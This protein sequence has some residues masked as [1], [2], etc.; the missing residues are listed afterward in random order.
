VARGN[1]TLTVT[2]NGTLQ[3]TRSTN[4]GSE[5]SGTVL[6]V[7]VDVNDLIRKGQAR[8]ELD[9]AK[10]RDQILRSR[11]VLAAATAKVTQTL[12]TVKEA[13]GRPGAPGRSGTHLGR[14]V[15]RRDRTRYRP[16]CT[17]TG[18]RRRGQRSRRRQRRAGGA[19]PGRDQPVEGV[20]PRPIGRRRA[21][22]YGGHRQR[23][24]GVAAGGDACLRSP[25]I[26]SGCACGCTSTRP[27]S[28]RWPRARTPASRSAP[29]PSRQYPAR[30]TRVG[31]GSTITDNVVTYLTYL[32]V[33]NS[34][35]SLR[36]GMTATATI[37]ASA[38]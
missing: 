14:P 37:T 38:A 32:D 16:R 34:D 19:G 23:G 20:D 5:L 11:A 29:I 4:I 25:K 13:H 10:L 26:W 9:T 27:T 36:P 15:A 8:V 30:I 21:D 31:F 12:T 7:N 33:D 3:P 6:K 24:G 28:A 2:A 18:D 17:R 1:L 35:L 22:A